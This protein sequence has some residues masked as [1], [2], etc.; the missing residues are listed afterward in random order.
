[1]TTLTPNSIAVTFTTATADMPKI[2][3]ITSKPSYT[4]IKRFQDK[5]NEN[6]MTIPSSQTDLGHLALVLDPTDFDTANGGIAFIPPVSPGNAPTDP[7][8]GITSN[9]DAARTTRGAT[10][11]DDAAIN[12]LPFTAPEAIRQYNQRKQDH[13]TYVQATIALKNQIINAVD[14][15][16]I[17]A[18]KDAI[19]LYAKVTPLTL[20]TH[21]W[22]T[23]GTIDQADQTANE[24]RMRKD[25]NPPNP[26]EELYEQLKEG[27][28]FASKGKETISDGQLIRWGYEIILKTGLFNRDCEKWRKKPETDKTWDKFKEH[29]SIA[30]DDRDKNT[31]ADDAGYS[32]N[33]MEQLIQQRVQ[34]EMSALLNSI[35]QE[36]DEA[37]PLTEETPAPASA[38]AANATVTLDA[39]AKLIDAK[40]KTAKINP[41]STTQPRPQGTIDGI[42]VTY[43]WSHG[44]T[45]NLFHN[46][47]TCRRCKEGHK[48]EATLN[49]RMGGSDVRNKKRET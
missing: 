20:L 9:S 25:W 44:I 37:P 11:A 22:T 33:K 19:T 2:S 48:K 45:A 26:I 17:S 49:N 1:M 14:D 42:P 18:Q 27:Q 4:S 3:T 32:A 8:T 30:E 40:L 16:Y 6:A 10:A 13:S 24:A 15:K 29:F 39:I 36:E 5:I 23:Y 46:S 35:S 43:C 12:M 28:V 7:T 41:T 34:A 38:Q 21:L 47:K 31:S